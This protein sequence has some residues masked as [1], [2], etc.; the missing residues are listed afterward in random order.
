MNIVCIGLN[1]ETAPVEVRERVAFSEDEALAFLGAPEDAAAER[2]LLSTCNRT[3]LYAVGAAADLADRLVAKLDDARGETVFRDGSVVYRREGAEAV[4]HLHRV[5]AGLDSMIL[6]EAQILGQVD[7]ALRTARAAGSAGAVLGRL[8]ETAIRLGGKVRAT[9]DIGRGAVSV[10]S[11]AVA[12]AAKIFGSLEG[13]KALVIGAGEMGSLAARHLRSAGVDTLGIANRTVA[14]AESLAAEVD[15]EAVPFCGV[16]QE[17]ARADVVVSA[18][19]GGVTMLT[20]DSVRGA[21]RSR[22]YRPF[23]VVDVSVP[24]SVDPAIRGLEHVFLQ[25]VDALRRIIDAN[26]GRRRKAAKKVKKAC[27]ESAARFVAWTGTLSVEPTVKELRL[28]LD[29]IARQELKRTLKKVPA[30]HRDA[31]E[32]L[33]RSLVS[34]VLHEPTRRLREEAGR[35]N[36]AVDR[37]AALRE[38]FGLEEAHEHPHRDEG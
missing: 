1:H 37:L 23:L 19:A 12:L 5:A 30:E 28:R 13:R 35:G 9:T 26:L 10:S 15:G 7:D 14:R 32:R 36:G 33:T 4:R 27:E 20:E 22:S 3:E 2:V 38:L 16:P 25:D 8:F 21:M 18:I 24:R 6:G 11:A 31:V 17:L 34:K 29:D